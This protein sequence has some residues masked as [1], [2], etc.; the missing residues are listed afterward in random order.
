MKDLNVVKFINQIRF[1]EYKKKKFVR[2]AY[3]VFQIIVVRYIDKSKHLQMN[4]NNSII[5][6]NLM[7]NI[8]TFTLSMQNLC[9]SILYS[10]NMYLKFIS[11]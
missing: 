7:Q 9:D 1:I 10:I 8:F 6:Q 5:H 3:L 4:K 2:H 11:T